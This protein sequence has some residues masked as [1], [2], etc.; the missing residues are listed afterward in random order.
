MIKWAN[1]S[2]N[3][4]ARHIGLLRGENLYQIKRGNNGI[5]RNLAEMIVTAFPEI[6]LLW[7]LTGEGQMFSTPELKGGDIK[8]FDLDIEANIRNIENLEPQGVM[9][10]PTQ[11]DGDFAMLYSG[12]AMGNIIPP[13]SIVILKKIIPQAII[14]GDECVI[15]TKNVVTLR[16]VR[17]EATSPDSNIA[18]GDVLRLASANS[19]AFDDIRLNRSEIEV[20]Y[21]VTAKLLIN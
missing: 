16:I 13:N 8:Y 6:N 21:K 15:I 18:Y 5:S 11:V 10:M 19:E 12:R 9:V 7:I 17:F 14:P 2:T 4:F 20:V 1:M 3:F